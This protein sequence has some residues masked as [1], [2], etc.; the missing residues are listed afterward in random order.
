MVAQILLKC[1]LFET[2]VIHRRKKIWL[3]RICPCRDFANVLSPH[4]FSHY[5]GRFS[6]ILKIQRF[7]FIIIILIDKES[8]FTILGKVSSQTLFET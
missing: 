8:F 5:S 1:I 6:L 4:C 2:L 3:L 7:T